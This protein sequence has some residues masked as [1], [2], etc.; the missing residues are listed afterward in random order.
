MAQM[1]MAS[2]TLAIVIFATITLAIVTSANIPV[3]VVILPPVIPLARVL[4]I[5]VF[6]GVV[7]VVS[8]DICFAVVRI[9]DRI[10]DVVMDCPFVESV[11]L[12]EAART[13][14]SLSRISVTT[15]AEE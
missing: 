4:P 3:P 1:A 14:C 6:P 5:I 8:A 15:R 13:A 7:L 9:K 10:K 2:S 12:L 11:S